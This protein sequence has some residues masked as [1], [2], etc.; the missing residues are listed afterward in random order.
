[1]SALPCAHARVRMN[2][3]CQLLPTPHFTSILFPLIW[4]HGGSVLRN[5]FWC[6][7]YRMNFRSK[8]FLIIQD[9]ILH[10]MLSFGRGPISI[11][12]NRLRYKL[13]NF[14][15]K[16]EISPLMHVCN[17]S[18]LCNFVK[19][20][21]SLDVFA[22]NQSYWAQ[23]QVPILRN[24]DQGDLR[25]ESTNTRGRLSLHIIYVYRTNHLNGKRVYP[26][27][28]ECNPHPIIWIYISDTY[29]VISR[30]TWCNLQYSCRSVMVD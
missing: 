8:I 18:N 9:F 3:F 20:R 29:L 26:V 16:N 15:S 10:S 28:I 12:N 1:M 4:A 30:C 11:I 17:C 2:T 27:D 23:L 24:M 14:R 7:F 21:W 25:L 6:V 13:F 22:W 5:I 19:L